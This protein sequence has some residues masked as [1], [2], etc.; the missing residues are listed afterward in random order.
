MYKKISEVLLSSKYRAGKTY[1]QNDL[2]R[3]ENIILKKLNNND[4]LSIAI[5]AFPFKIMNP[6]K[7][8]GSYASEGELSSLNRLKMIS[9]DLYNIGVDLKWNIITDGFFYA[10]ELSVDE[11]YVSLYIKRVKEM[12]SEINLNANF[13]ELDELVDKS[14]I[15]IKKRL[16]YSI[17]EDRVYILR[18]AGMIN[19]LK[20]KEK[21]FEYFKETSSVYMS[22][23]MLVENN[24]QFRK[25]AEYAATL[26]QERK[27]LVDRSDIFNNFFPNSIKASIQPDVNRNLKNFAI[28][29]PLSIRITESKRRNLFPWLGVSYYNGKEII[30]IYYADYLN[31]KMKKL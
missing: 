21:L 24:S 4:E 1:S 30:N 29:R 6:L 16:S 28:E 19:T 2:V 23:V 15:Q 18:T 14:V 10:D 20:Y 26:Y 13:I 22:M 8:N 5:S 7:T 27:K 3:L 11:S 9:Q 12:A 25:E 31:K 17:E